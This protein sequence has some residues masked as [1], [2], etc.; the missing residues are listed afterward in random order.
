MS[1]GYLV[2]LILVAIA[3]AIVLHAWWHDKRRGYEKPVDLDVIVGLVLVAAAMIVAVITFVLN[4][5]G[6]L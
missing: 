2:A 3:V 6:G 4:G 1:A 5:M